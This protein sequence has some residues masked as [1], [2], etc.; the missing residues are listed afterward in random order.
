MA[1]DRAL[2]ARHM[3]IQTGPETERDR[4]DTPQSTRIGGQPTQLTRASLAF[5]KIWLALWPTTGIVGAF[6]VLSLFGVWTLI[7]TMLHLTILLVGSVA[8]LFSLYTNLKAV[9]WPTLFD[10][11]RR[12]EEVNG[13]AHRPLRSWGDR[14]IASSSQLERDLWRAHRQRLVRQIGRLSPAWPR[15][16]LSYK[17]PWTLRALLLMLIILGFV[18]VGPDW[19]ARL[20]AG[21]SPEF[22]IG[23]TTRSVADVWLTPP[24]YTGRAPVF[25]THTGTATEEDH[26]GQD[27][28]ILVPE[29]SE[30]HVRVSASRDPTLKLR[31]G[32]SSGYRVQDFAPPN[33]NFYETSTNL[34]QSSDIKLDVGAESWSWSVDIAPDQPPFVAWTS[35]AE[36]TNR[37]AM[38]LSYEARDDYRVAGVTL[39]IRRALTEI[40]DSSG[41]TNTGPRPAD[42]LLIDLPVPASTAENNRQVSFQDLTAHRWA[43]LPVKM[44]LEASDELGQQTTS[45]IVPIILPERV[46]LAPL[47]QALIEQRKTLITEPDKKE[48]VADVLGALTDSPENFFDDAILYF[49]LRTTYWRLR[50]ARTEQD[51]DSVIDLLWHIALRIEDGNSSMAEQ[52]LRAAQDALREALARNAPDEE[53]ERLMD[54]L[55]AAFE[56]YMASMAERGPGEM[57]TDQGLQDQNITQVT[58]Q[59]L[60]RMLDAI[61]ELNEAGAREQA[62]ELLSAFQSIIESL[63]SAPPLAAPTPAQKATEE[64]LQKLGDMIGDQRSLMDETHQSS[65]QKGGDPSESPESQSGAR[66]TDKGT[67]QGGEGSALAA[68]QQ[69]LRNDLETLTQMLETFGKDLPKALGRAGKAMEDAKEALD[70]G[71][72]TYAVDRQQEAIDR[73]R[74]GAQAMAQQ[75]M[76][77]MAQSMDGQGRP[78]QR[79]TDPLGRPLPNGGTDDGLSVKVPAERDMQ[80][81][82]EILQELRRRASD[83][84]RPG[85]E[86]EYIE[87]LLRRF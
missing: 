17:D 50:N 67:Q 31:D 69:S 76:E 61:Q 10:A 2:T 7:P 25:L 48:Y 32:T 30:L 24:A 79:R 15:S 27:K 12:V 57:Q 62:Q 75:L 60:A 49:T 74:A 71:D 63:Q 84:Q 77:E 13:L 22:A 18:G 82:R 43:G 33:N 29:G 16:F 53:I 46:F 42:P 65:Q 87:R 85:L 51:I 72:M 78:N 44:Q 9:D 59:D 23:S 6:I 86:L 35:E 21:L 45:E 3:P 81:A 64:A 1:R 37:G 58:P 28:G 26:S 52:N 56:A 38:R 54:E 39:K 36:Q 73:L 55:R 47:A 68:E 5:E 14:P 83:R 19:K 80:R 8:I 11:E 66:P 4:Q 20:M 40:S 34:D 41:E 70:E